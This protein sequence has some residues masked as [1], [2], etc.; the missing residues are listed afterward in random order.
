[1]PYTNE[2]L[3]AEGPQSPQSALN[4]DFNEIWTDDEIIEEGLSEAYTDHALEAEISGEAPWAVAEITE[5]D[6]ISGEDAWEGEA[7]ITEEDDDVVLG[8]PGTS[9]NPDG[10]EKLATDQYDQLYA[11]TVRNER[12][13][14]QADREQEDGQGLGTSDFGSIEKSKKKVEISNRQY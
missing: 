9:Y 8:T 11:A 7:E 4:P 3:A 1:M 2:E 14:R 6:E 13:I 5:E 12:G 10:S